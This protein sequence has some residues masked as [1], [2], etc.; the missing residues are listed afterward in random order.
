MNARAQVQPLQTASEALFA[1]RVAAEEIDD[2]PP[3]SVER[4][5]G[6]LVAEQV[7]LARREVEQ[8]AD[9][10]IGLAVVV[11][12]MSFEVAFEFGDAPVRKELPA[13]REAPVQLYFDRA[14]IAD[15]IGEAVRHTVRAGVARG[16]AILAERRV[17]DAQ[18]P[19]D[20]VRG[21][22]RRD[23]AAGRELEAD[24]VDRRVEL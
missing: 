1:Q 24:R 10:R 21:A 19:I 16:L 15:R 3:I 12:E 23:R 9:G 14:V 8:R 11:A 18:V 5:D 13:V 6:E 4:A 22:L 20:Q 17:A 7:E 2:V